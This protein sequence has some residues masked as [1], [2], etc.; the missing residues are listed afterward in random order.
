MVLRWWA[1]RRPTP[2]K[3]A[4]GQGEGEWTVFVWD[5]GGNRGGLEEEREKGRREFG[6]EL[7]ARVDS[8]IQSQFGVSGGYVSV[9]LAAG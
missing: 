5:R 1:E 7:I 8:S 9:C 6:G 3:P 2:V 4:E